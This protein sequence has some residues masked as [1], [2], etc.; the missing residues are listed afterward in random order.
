MTKFLQTVKFSGMNNTGTIG[1]IVC[2]LSQQGLNFT[3]DVLNQKCSD[4]DKFITFFEVKVK[5]DQDIMNWS[6][7][8]LEG[9]ELR[10]SVL[11]AI[12]ILNNKWDN[13]NM[14]YVKI[15]F[16]YAED[17]DTFYLDGKHDVVEE[18]CIM[19]EDG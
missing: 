19:L 15:E 1:E 10:D 13:N 14:D 7:P 11:D 17:V 2:A 6:R 3:I 18:I 16:R 5:R 9:N 8:Y 4:S 12:S